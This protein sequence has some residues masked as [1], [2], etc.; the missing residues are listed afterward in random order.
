MRFNLNSLRLSQMA[1]DVVGNAESRELI[2]LLLPS[3]RLVYRISKWINLYC[4]NSKC[5]VVVVVY[6]HIISPNFPNSPHKLF[7]LNISGNRR[8]ATSKM[9]MS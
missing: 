9:T 3:V 6:N 5:N 8:T 2:A 7:R 1:A 4:L